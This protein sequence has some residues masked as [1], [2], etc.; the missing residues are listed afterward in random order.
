MKPLKLTIS[1]FGP[2]A[3][4]VEID[5]QKLGTNGVYLIT[6][7]TGAGKTTIFDAITYALYGGASGNVRDKK[8]FRS[9]YANPQ[10]ETFVE[11]TFVYRDQQ[12]VIRRNPEY[13]RPRKKGEGMTKQKAEVEFRYPDDRLPLT[14]EKE[15]EKTIEDLIGLDRAQFT[16]I[17]MIAQGDFQKLLLAGTEEREKIFQRIFQT[18]FYERI[19]DR[20]REKAAELDREYKETQKSV[21]Q[22]AKRVLYEEEDL[23]EEQ[24][25]KLREKEYQGTTTELL[26]IVRKL[27]EQDEQQ[28]LFLREQLD[29]CEREM[30]ELGRKIGKAEKEEEDRRRLEQNQ[31]EKE[32]IQPLLLEA[33]QRRE[34]AKQQ[35]EETKQL[36]QFIEEGKKQLELYETLRALEVKQ[37]EI[38]RKMEEK[39]AQKEQLENTQQEIKNWISYAEKELST[40]GQEKEARSQLL[41]Q[42]EKWQQ[43]VEK[44]KELKEEYKQKEQFIKEEQKKQSIAVQ[45]KE[46]IKGQCEALTK[47]L[48]ELEGCEIK[49][50]E[51]RT[52]LEEF[53]SKR[54][55]LFSLAEEE[56]EDSKNLLK[57]SENNEKEKERFLQARE[58]KESW[59]RKIEQAKEIEVQIERYR[60]EEEKRQQKI[61]DLEEVKQE[62]F[63]HVEIWNQYQKAQQ[64]YL[65]CFNIFTAKR[66]EVEKQEQLF[67][68]AQAGIL[69]S[70][71]VD[72]EKCPVC[73]A[74]HHPERATMI[75]GAPT[76]EELYEQTEEVNQKKEEVTKKSQK[77][78]EVKGSLEKSGAQIQKKVM[79]L[80]APTFTEQFF[81]EQKQWAMK[82]E[83]I[84]VLYTEVMEEKQRFIK[85]KEEFKEKRRLAERKKEEKEQLQQKLNIRNQQIEQLEK[86]VTEQEKALSVRQEKIHHIR[87]QIQQLIEIDGENTEAFQQK[88]QEELSIWQERYRTM[89]HFYQS[90]QQQV[91]EKKEKAHLLESYTRE[92]EEKEKVLQELDRAIQVLR[93]QKIGIKAQITEQCR[94]LESEE[95]Q[96][97]V[98]EESEFMPQ[99]EVRIASV[100]ERLQT[101]QKD[102]LDL[103]EQITRKEQ[104]ETMLLE[105]KQRVEEISKDLIKHTTDLALK[106]EEW[107]QTESQRK[108]LEQ[109]LQDKTEQQV[110]EEMEKW[111]KQQDIALK[112]YEEAKEK[113]EMY[114][115]NMT[116]IDLAIQLL[117]A[118]LENSQNISLE[119][120]QGAQQEWRKKNQE[121]SKKRDGLYLQKQTNAS[122][123]EFIVKKQK[124]IGE[125]EERWKCLKS[126]SDT[127]NGQIAGKEK[128][129]FE[130][131][132]QMQYFERI[133]KYA[134]IRLMEMSGGQYELE[135]QTK[136][137]NKTSKTGLDLE[138]IDHY[139][140]TKRSVRTLSGGET[141][142]ASLALALG[143]SDEIQA[144]SGGIQLDTMFIDEGFGSLDEESLGQAM[145]VLLKLSE[146]S[147]MIGIISHVAELKEKIDKKI[148]VTK[149]KE[150]DGIGSSIAITCS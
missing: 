82:K 150:E 3:K 77:A 47:R 27:V 38:K 136:A 18:Q 90:L 147:R 86:Q 120:I 31:A 34:Y 63:E 94:L 14:K 83:E 138:I 100:E 23:E 93:S 96:K 139:N 2:Y 80:L 103:Q 1:A 51:Q 36:E 111:C 126:L 73:G 131:Y 12:Y 146:G 37:Q 50:V 65:D 132:V 102:I 68:D 122:V 128:I 137:S 78:G 91:A 75:D 52:A 16:Q 106:E 62:I 143:L 134:N 57:E 10:T 145:N 85:Q 72:G 149:R 13:E 48:K 43:W 140:G 17:A 11:L 5:F 24:I 141:F 135:R 53:E 89:E 7:D 67:Y 110:K 55:Q 49:E 112:D 20:L 9:K 99:I 46:H 70:S 129:T 25:Q 40:L 97:V 79:L 64:E 133:L 119:E 125:L 124:E 15:V 30:A 8:M 59:E 109:D 4:Q 104:F 84:Q 148:E 113:E 45:T 60:N 32:K 92:K 56:K 19:Q 76:R 74:T 142:K 54:R 101:L 21:I 61:D 33:I 108:Q 130:T 42:Q 29:E 117:H 69:A 26:Q 144:Y 87:K 105:N 39:N 81:G 22:A 44:L 114:Q 41:Y 28:L 123:E 58:E 71:L 121:L 118:Q 88:I 127:A 115:A 116:E 66:E 107:K 35:M 6:G 95:A 98:G